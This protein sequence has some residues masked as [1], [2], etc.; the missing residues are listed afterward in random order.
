[1]TKIEP[2]LIDRLE[3]YES[4]P[5]TISKDSMQKLCD[6]ICKDPGFMDR[7]PV[8]VNYI[9]DKKAWFVY[10]GSQRVRACKELGWIEIPCIIDND[11]EEEIMQRRMLIDNQHSG[12][13]DFD[14]L[15][16]EFEIDMLL[17][18]GFT[19]KDFELD[20]IDDPIT[21]SNEKEKKCDKC[22]N[23]GWILD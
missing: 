3:F 9:K 12:D 18:V 7:R 8:L 22:P 14:I 10:A 6:S 17:D 4:N 15:A 13:W 23:C 2:V 11:L 19:E 21:S 20:E 16:N 1:M 5:R